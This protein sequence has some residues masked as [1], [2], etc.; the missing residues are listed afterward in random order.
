VWQLVAGIFDALFFGGL[1][2]ALGW[3][4]FLAKRSDPTTTEATD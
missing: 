2:V 1:G 4:G 3:V